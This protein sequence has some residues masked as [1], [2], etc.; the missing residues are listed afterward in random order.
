MTLSILRFSAALAVMAGSGLGGTLSAQE[1]PAL[2]D[3]TD[4][5]VTGR[6]QLVIEPARD[7]NLREWAQFVR[8]YSVFAVEADWLSSMF[9]LPHNIPVVFRQCG[10]VNAYWS[11]SRQE[12]VL[13]YELLDDLSREF[14]ASEL[15]ADEEYPEFARVKATLGAGEFI[16]Y[17]E[18][19]HALIDLFD[20]A[21]T[22]REED[23]VDQFASYLMLEH[24]DPEMVEAAIRA[25]QAI[26]EW[27]GTFDDEVFA[28]EHSFGEQR[29]YN[30]LCYV[31]AANPADYG[32]LI[33]QGDL[34]A[35]RGEL[36]L[37]EWPRI[38]R[39]WEEKLEGLRLDVNPE[40]GDEDD[41]LRSPE[42]RWKPINQ[43]QRPKSLDSDS[44]FPHIQADRF[45]S[46]G[47]LQ[48]REES[49]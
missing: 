26:Y 2:G 33:T 30:I 16:L 7:P 20:L 41:P 31:Y 23:V 25:A 38:K 44:L 47:L 10:D 32:A 11:E 9:R 15:F 39:A 37:R 5:L 19:G 21:M 24:Q 48:G 18:V 8:D 3:S 6:L 27:G 14:E 29:Y 36:C 35:R 28:D 17:H 4:T 40:A 22:G 45:A 43:P 46:G 13:C 49:R 12:I 34:P 42:S 1:H